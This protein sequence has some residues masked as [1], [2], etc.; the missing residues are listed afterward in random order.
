[1]KRDEDIAIDSDDE[2]KNN[3]SRMEGN[4]Q[5]TGNSEPQDP[6]FL[7]INDLNSKN[8]GNAFPKKSIMKQPKVND[9]E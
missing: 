4:R 3:N 9:E 6:N 2:S 5:Y 8:V 7:N 1:M